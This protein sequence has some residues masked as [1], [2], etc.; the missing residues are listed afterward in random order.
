MFLSA[1]II[2]FVWFGLVCFAWLFSFVWLLPLNEYN[3]SDFDDACEEVGAQWFDVDPGVLAANTVV[4]QDVFFPDEMI[5]AVFVRVVRSWLEDVV[6]RAGDTSSAVL[7]D[8]FRAREHEE[9]THDRFYRRVPN[10]MF[11]FR[12]VMDGFV[13]MYCLRAVSR[14]F[15]KSVVRVLDRCSRGIL[16]R[17]VDAAYARVHDLLRTLRVFGKGSVGDNQFMATVVERTV[18]STCTGFLPRPILLGIG[19]YRLSVRGNTVTVPRLFCRDDDGGDLDA[20]C[21]DGLVGPDMNLFLNWVLFPGK[22]PAVVDLSGCGYVCINKDRP[23]HRL[24][25]PGRAMRFVITCNVLLYTCAHDGLEVHNAGSEPAVFDIHM[26]VVRLSVPVQPGRTVSF[27]AYDCDS[28]L[29]LDVTWPGAELLFEIGTKPSRMCERDTGGPRYLDVNVQRQM[30]F[31]TVRAGKSLHSEGNLY[32]PR[33]VPGSIPAQCMWMY[34]TSNPPAPVADALRSLFAAHANVHIFAP[35]K[36]EP[37]RLAINSAHERLHV[38]FSMQDHLY[39]PNSF[40]GRHLPQKASVAR[41]IFN[42]FAFPA[43]GTPWTPTITFRQLQESVCPVDDLRR[44]LPQATLYF[45]QPP[46]SPRHLAQ[47]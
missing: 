9:A 29:P 32:I 1:A 22:G 35:E 18:K 10:S 27:P 37:L 7:H 2:S 6:V 43:D 19:A 21:V 23:G 46:D 4:K 16:G 13:R 20:V 24:S 33:L 31:I 44:V 17:D 39:L 38:S 36:I 14:Q 26:D 41:Y 34:V 12:D 42:L 40:F 8:A 15:H 11:W 47:Q 30:E 3:M 28:G 5:E 25:E 45:F